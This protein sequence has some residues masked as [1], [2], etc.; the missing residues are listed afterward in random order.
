MKD[1]MSNNKKE[2]LT[3][4][5]VIAITQEE[6]KLKA[7]MLQKKDGNIEL[8]WTKIADFDQTSWQH[9]A[10][11]L[12]KQAEDTIV[13]GFNSTGVVFYRIEVPAV[14]ADELAAL[15]Q[16]QA[17]ARLPLPA[18]QME[19][20]WRAG[21]AKDGQVVVTIAAARKNQLQDF[22]A[23]VR[24]FEPARIILDC[25]GIVE[26]WRTVFSGTAQ[27]A[28]VVSVGQ[29]STQLCLVENGQLN[30]VVS[31]DTGANDFSDGQYEI[32]ERFA[33]DAK[34]VLELFGSVDQTE[35]PVFVLSD[36]REVIEKIVACLVSAGLKA[37]A[38]LPKINKLSSETEHGA[39]DIYEYRAAIGLGVMAFDPESNELDIFK[40]LYT[41]TKEKSKPWLHSP[42]LTGTVAAVL[43]ALFVIVFYFIDV[44]S[45]SAI[46]KRLN[47]SESKV[48]CNL[49][50]EWQKLIKTIALQRPDLLK[51]FSKM[52]SGENDGI[53]LDGFNFKKGQAITISGQAKGDDQLYKF[54]KS[55]L[56]KKGITEVKI[57]S[58]KKEAKG[59]KLNFR[60]SFHYKKF[61]KKKGRD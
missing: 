45:L 14:K 27:S 47:G 41:S 8:V 35:L 20:A 18:E 21:K 50:M 36:G 5:A 1:M 34:S 33:Q 53:M 16:L 56:N 22:V 46:E 17:E 11:A 59:E 13:A 48:D 25:E 32:A 43:L 60:M 57:Q 39:E 42:K 52:S 61:T 38:V 31:L 6:N 29:Y 26:V 15:V 58:A 12:T 37:K 44:A 7:V 49:L 51:L 28:L 24:S 2:I 40:R 3:E 4:P 55:L 19:L 9:F 30:N 10:H 23:H 54:Q